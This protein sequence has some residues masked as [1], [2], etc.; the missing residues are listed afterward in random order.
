MNQSAYL[1]RLQRVDTQ[2]DQTDLRLAEIDRLLS[3]DERIKKAKQAADETRREL[4]KYRLALRSAEHATKET[5]IKM[6]QSEA[7][8]YSGSIRNPKELQDL[9]REI[10]SLKRHLTVLED[11]QL[12]AMM[13]VETAEKMDADAQSGL[14]YAQAEV[15]AQKAGLA[16]ERDTLLKNRQRLVTER[17]TTLPPISPQN[18]EI[19]Q[20]IREQKKGI[21]VSAV[22]DDA[23]ALCGAEVRIGESQAS[24]MQTNLHYC[25][26]CGRIIFAG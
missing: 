16:G 2:I 13:D 25:T 5:R 11:A 1:H 15:T 8:L 3:E 26:S 21:A 23:C 14:L 10:E 7:S 18:L 20:R 6:E 24:R 19:Y 17:S 22:E 12:S 9:Q 4:E